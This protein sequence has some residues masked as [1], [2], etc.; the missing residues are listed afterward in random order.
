VST[1]TTPLPVI[2]IRSNLDDLRVAVLDRRAADVLSFD[3]SFP[4][5][6]AI[7][8]YAKETRFG[9]RV[10]TAVHGG[11]DSAARVDHVIDENKVHAVHSEGDIGDCNTA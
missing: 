2:S 10:E 11:A 4:P 6:A 8:Q 1:R 3:G 9:R 7:D 5:V